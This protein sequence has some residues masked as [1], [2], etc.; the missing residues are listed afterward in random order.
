MT[1]KALHYF[2]GGNTARGYFSLYDSN[3]AGLEKVFILK[4]GPGT[5]KSTLMRK[6]AANWLEKDY[7]V[8]FIHCS[9]DPGSV[10]GII[11][12]A[13][14]IGIVDGTE[15]HVV[16]PKAPGAIEE[17]VNLGDA[18]DSQKLS[19]EKVKIIRL[20]DERKEAY[21]QAYKAYADA[22]SCS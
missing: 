16:E 11:F 20:M 19:T 3:F 8:E 12:P 22:L 2:A 14:K 4:G 7:D 1:G 9:S 10:D 18:W 6:I 13:L 21:N 5:G 15:P 17:Y